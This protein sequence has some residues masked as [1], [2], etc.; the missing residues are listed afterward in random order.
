MMVTV[1]IGYRKIQHLTFVMVIM[2]IMPVEIIADRIFE[3]S[4]EITVKVEGIGEQA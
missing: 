3:G 1:Q 4:F 2:I